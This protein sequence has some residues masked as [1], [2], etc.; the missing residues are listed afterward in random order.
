MEK[1]KIETR[2]APSKDEKKDLAHGKCVVFRFLIKQQPRKTQ[3]SHI[4]LQRLIH[5]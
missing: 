1:K 2:C 4:L 5:T 3:K